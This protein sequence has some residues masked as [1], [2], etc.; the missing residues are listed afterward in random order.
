MTD[1]KTR[2][3]KVL[4]RAGQLSRQKEKRKITTYKLTS[5][6]LAVLLVY[7]ISRLPAV[8][9]TAT[10]SDSC[11]SILLI[12][13]MGGY[14]LTAVSAFIISAC[15]TAALIKKKHKKEDKK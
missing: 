5:A 15:I 6:T 13:G 8:C 10:V 2:I 11:G 14:V 9:K 1:S 4:K 3:N 12:D 7:C